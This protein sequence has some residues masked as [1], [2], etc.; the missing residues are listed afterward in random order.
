MFT[1]LR[2][3]VQLR[4]AELTT[5]ICVVTGLLIEIFPELFSFSQLIIPEDNHS[6]LYALILENST[7][8]IFFFPFSLTGQFRKGSPVRVFR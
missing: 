8:H 3:S 4:G 2:F 1:R 7:G 6:M 5:G